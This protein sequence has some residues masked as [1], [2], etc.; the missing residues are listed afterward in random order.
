MKAIRASILVVLGLIGISAIIYLVT[1]NAIQVYYVQLNG[2]DL[3]EF[4]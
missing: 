3:D 4:E 2:K 1:M